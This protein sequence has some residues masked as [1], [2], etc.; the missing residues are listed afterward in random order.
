VAI[1]ITAIQVTPA[2]VARQG[3][4]IAG[5]LYKLLIV[6]HRSLLLHQTLAAAE[7]VAAEAVVAAAAAVAA[8]QLDHNFISL[9]L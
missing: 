9:N 8:D 5:Q 4:K 7:A 2:I 6:H 1:Q 3:N